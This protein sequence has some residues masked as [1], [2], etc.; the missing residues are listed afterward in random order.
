MSRRLVVSPPFFFSLPGGR[1]AGETSTSQPQPTFVPTRDKKKTGFGPARAII[2]CL[3]LA[4]R[5]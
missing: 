3:C 1:G 4:V 2:R 5:A